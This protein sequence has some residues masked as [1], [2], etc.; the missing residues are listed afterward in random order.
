M[1][2]IL[3]RAGCGKSYYCMNDIKKNLD[4]SYNGPLIYMVPEQFSLTAEYDLSNVI[5]RGGLLEAQVLTFKRL[6]YRI[7][8]EFGYKEKSISKSAKA[9]L[10]YSVMKD[11]EKEL[12]LLNGVDKKPGLV[13]KVADLISEFKRYNITP[14]ILI[15][16]NIKN[17]RLKNKLRELAYIYEEYEKRIDGRFL[18]QD[19]NLKVVLKFIENS[20]ILDGA[21]I[22]IDG[23][24]GFT[25]QELEVIKVLNRKTDLTIAI[26]SDKEN[27]ELFL[28]NNRCIDKIK[29]FA[30]VE[31]IYLENEYRLHSNELKH[32]E[33]TF[34]VFPIKIYKDVPTNIDITI[35]SN[36]YE[37]IESIAISILKKVRDE[38]MR[39]ENIF[40]LSRNIENY[41][42][43]FKMIFERYNIPYFIDEKTE[44]SLQPLISL[45][46][47]VLYICKKNFNKEDVISYLKTGLTNIKNLND[48]DKLENYV[49]KY[50]ITG[51]RW[52][53][54][55]KYENND[56]E[57]H[58]NNIRK[59]V[60]EPILKMKEK[61]KNKTI[62]K[63]YAICIYEFL[64]QID[65]VASLEK[66][67]K[68]INEN[69][70]AQNSDISIANTYIQVWN[71]FA[72]LLDELVKTTGEENMSFD[73]FESILK[74]GISEKQIGLIPTFK[75]QVIIGD[76]SRSRSS[77]I[78][79]L[80]IVGMNDGVFPMQYTEEGFIDDNERNMLINSNIEIA[81]DTKTMLLE[82]NF[83][84]YKALTVP[85]DELHLSYP[86]SSNDGTVL[87]SSSII[88]Q[89]RKIFPEIKINDLI[90]NGI[91]DNDIINTEK[92]T[93]PHIANMLYDNKAKTRFNALRTWYEENNHDYANL[94]R[95]SLNYT[96]ATNKIDKI[97]AKSLYGSVINS[98]VSK[99]ETYASCP[100]EFYLKYGL[101]LQER[102]VYKLMTL[103]IGTFMHDILDKFSKY[104]QD[105]NLSFRII[106]KEDIEK[107]SLSIVD[108]ILKD[109]KYSIF[110]SNNKLKFLSKKL[111]RVVGRI[112]WVISLHIRNSDFDVLESE[113][114]FG[115]GEKYPA[116][117]IELTNGNKLCLNGKIDRIDI[118]KTEDGNYIR[119]IDYKS[120]GKEIKLSNVYYGL[121]LQLITYLD[122]ASRNEFIPGG[123]LYL[124]LDDPIIKTNKDV[125]VEELEEQI[126]MKLRMNGIILADAKLVKAMDKDIVK[127]SSNINLSM[128][129]DGTFSKMPTATEEEIKNLCKHVKRLFKKFAEEILDGN[130]KNEPIR[131][132]GKSPCVYC[133]YKSICNFD[134]ELGNRF[135]YIKEL[136]SDEV[137]EQTR[138]M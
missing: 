125:S 94:I 102:K 5:G 134:R 86:I 81:K 57:D 19:D 39:Y 107:I 104:L 62:A 129:E 16:A 124:K 43:V 44:L 41:G 121:Q 24:D 40:I 23:F 110:T 29:R 27:S 75:D 17:D 53:D 52:L 37:E 113:A 89:I 83:N 9:M 36:L 120:S 59:Q 85:R 50:G 108:D 130:I 96:N 131:I 90:I 51:S 10:I 122:V 54:D 20:K 14:E 67:L 137:Y 126:R 28:L 69:P 106:S 22:W 114:K 47:S 128:K 88:N 32:L 112:L 45:V 7:Y 58:I 33:K 8:N 48:V 55:W 64:T 117:E 21:K 11:L 80:Y 105:N 103:D 119:I 93:F 70:N 6:C 68:E 127:E 78:D 115:E 38:K 100:F 3:G 111:K 84:I 109:F 26:S 135:K 66:R 63:D 73:K 138:L 49:L 4:E 133:D 25:P 65:V 60:I 46:L 87:R 34:N 18:D 56:E 1:K 82:E 76:I 42:P 132:K 91:K 61:I 95:E 77:E 118:A 123:A 99:M 101:K 79:A 116:I 13:T 92:S 136:K 30:N 71:I 72:E 12:V 15:N 97:F 31:E 35:A 2:L 74:K 98:S